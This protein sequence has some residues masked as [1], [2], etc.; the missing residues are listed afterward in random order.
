[1]LP[2]FAAL[3]T[4]TLA[5]PTPQVSPTNGTLT[6]LAKYEVNCNAGGNTLPRCYEGGAAGCRC[7]SFGTFLCQDA[8]CRQYCGCSEYVYLC[9]CGD[10]GR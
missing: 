8:E 5:S 1:M 4:T 6:A 3:F 10:R 2:L 9:L 7:D